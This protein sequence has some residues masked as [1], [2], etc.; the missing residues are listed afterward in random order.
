[1][2]RVYKSMCYCTNARRSANALTEY[3]DNMFK[4]VGLTVAQYYLLINLK[5]LEKANITQWAEYVGLERSTM[6]RNVSTLEKHGLIHVVKGKGKVFEL[7]EFGRD[8]IEKAIPI[9]EKA[10]NEIKE[11]IGEEDAEAIR[12][13]GEKLQ[14]LPIIKE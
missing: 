11:Y 13:I 7:T 6:V 10:Q 4:N 14:N 12:R 3:Y 8:T 5:R 2:P 1:M 9:W